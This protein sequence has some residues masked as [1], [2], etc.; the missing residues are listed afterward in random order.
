[1]WFTQGGGDSVSQGSSEEQKQK[2]KGK[3]KKNS[4]S[5]VDQGTRYV[6]CSVIQ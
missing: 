1:M 4:I 3:D 2:L 5:S 6:A